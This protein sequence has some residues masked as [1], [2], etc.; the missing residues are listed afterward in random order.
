MNVQTWEATKA[1]RRFAAD[2]LIAANP[3]LIPVSEANN[4]LV[5]AAKNI[6]IELR[7]AF[8]GVKF[9]VKSSR[10]SGGD[11]IRVDWIDGPTT[12]QVDAIVDRYKA[13]T[14]SGLDDSYTYRGDHAF[15]DAFGDAR[16]V[17]TSREF[18]DRALSSVLG[19]VCRAY[20]APVVSVADYR[21]GRSWDVRAP[22]GSDVGREIA[23]AL[24]RHTYC[25]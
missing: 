2:A 16:F 25:V 14:F 1:A 23:R 18:S 22:N 11:S 4:P 5:A 3:H 12:A 10:F 13:G 7:A 15:V 6:R 21:A 19:R 8:P 20:G 9:A 24:S 17:S